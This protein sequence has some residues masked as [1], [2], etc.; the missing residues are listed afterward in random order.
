MNLYWRIFTHILILL[1][2]CIPLE[3]IGCIVLLPVVYYQGGVFTQ[4]PRIIRWFDNADQF[5]GRDTSTYQAVAESGWWNRYLWLAFRNPS[6]YFGYTVLGH[7]V[8]EKLSLVSYDADTAS[9]PIGDR[10]G[11]NPG[12]EY[13][14]V[15]DAGTEVWQYHKIIKWSDTKCARFLIGWKIFDIEKNEVGSIIQ[16]ACTIQPYKDYT[17]N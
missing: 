12:T 15:N 5:I 2:V 6:N 4:L 14:V 7:K 10:V 13:T 16:W 11:E 8:K 17:G 3:L 1:L 9:L